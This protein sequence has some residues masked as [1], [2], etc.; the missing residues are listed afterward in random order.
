[1]S[2][3]QKVYDGSVYTTGFRR[4]T[5]VTSLR[6]D[7][8]LREALATIQRVREAVDRLPNAAARKALGRALDGE[9]G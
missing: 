2:A 3:S 5:A 1:M 9:K 8:Q 7:E 4:P 6:R